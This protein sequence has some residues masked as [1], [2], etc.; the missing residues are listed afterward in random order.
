M[1]WTVIPMIICRPAFMLMGWLLGPESRRLLHDASSHP[2]PIRVS[3]GEFLAIPDRSQPL[4]SSQ[5]RD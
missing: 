3:P 4:L 5:R 1:A 2:P